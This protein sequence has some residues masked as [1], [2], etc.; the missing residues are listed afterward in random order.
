[1]KHFILTL[2]LF[3]GVIFAQRVVMQEE[4]KQA[5][6]NFENNHGFAFK[7]NNGGIAVAGNYQKAF[8]ATTALLAEISIRSEKD[9]QEQKF[10]NYFGE[11]IIPN[12][13]NYMLAVPIEVG[14][15]Q[16]IFAHKVD[17]S[18]RPFVEATVGPQIALVYPYFSD[19]NTNAHLDGNEEIYDPL[20]A[21]KNAKAQIGVG[22]SFNIGIAFGKSKKSLQSIRFGMS[23]SHYKKAIELLEPSIKAGQKTFYSPSIVLVFGKIRK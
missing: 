14:L 8:N 15:H 18:F 22:G 6:Y 23:V 20:S 4:T 10:Y 12:K 1:M 3:S 13:Y 21:V 17:E 19:L 16:R 7:F 2:F 9:E 5:L 11:S